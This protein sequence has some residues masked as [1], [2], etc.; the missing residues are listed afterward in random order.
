MRHWSV[1]HDPY[2]ICH[3]RRHLY[4]LA[5]YIL[6]FK[7]IYRLYVIFVEVVSIFGFLYLDL[8]W[9][10]IRIQFWY[11]PKYISLDLL[12]KTLKK[13]LTQKKNVVECWRRRRMQNIAALLIVMFILP[14]S[15]TSKTI[16]RFL[17]RVA[18]IRS[19]GWRCRDGANNYKTF[20]YKVVRVQ[21]EQKI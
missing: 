21:T 2:S 14:R 7:N 5:I 1:A 9:R 3:R 16:N 17:L 6:N 20:R 13:R 4:C 10:T 19:K 18:K 8:H 12:R 11:H 15:E